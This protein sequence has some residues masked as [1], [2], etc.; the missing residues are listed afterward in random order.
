MAL[1][2]A[3]VKNMPT[4]VRIAALVI[5][6]AVLAAAVALS[7]APINYLVVA[8]VLTAGISL[9]LYGVTLRVLERRKI[10]PFELRLGENA[11]AAPNQ[12]RDPAARARLD[13]LRKKFE[14]GVRVFREH[15]KDLYSI[16]WYLVAGEPGSGKTEAVRHSGVGFPPGLQDELQGAGGTLNMNWWFTN[17]AVILDTAGRLLFEDVEPGTTSEWKE[18]LRLLRQIRPNCPVNGLLLVIPADSLVRDTGE[19]IEE[20]AGRIAAQ[21]DAIQ[22]SLGVRFPVFVVITKADLINGFREFFDEMTDPVVQHQILGWSNPGSLDDAFDPGEVERHLLSV[23]ERL[24]RRRLRLVGDPPKVGKTASRLARADALYAFPDSMIRLAPRLRR[25][26]EMVFV[27][28]EWSTR[29]LFLRGIYFT[30][31]MR[32]G[33][34]LDQDLAEVLGVDVGSLPEGRAWERDRSYFLRDLFLGKIFKER[35]LVTRAASASRSKRR[36]Q[37]A[38]LGAAAAAIVVVGVLTWIGN[39]QLREAILE[40]KKF[41]T[42]VEQLARNMQSDPTIFDLVY[43]DGPTDQMRYQGSTRAEVFDGS[44]NGVLASPAWGDATITD[45][46]KLASERAAKAPEPPPIFRPVASIFGNPFA[47]TMEAQRALFARTVLEPL[48]DQ[49]RSKLANLDESSWT[50]EATGALGELMRLE[51]DARGVAAPSRDM[52]NIERLGTFVLHGEPEAIKSLREHDAD[53]LQGVLARSYQRGQDWPPAQVRGEP[54]ALARTVKQGVETFVAHWSERGGADSRTLAEIEALGNAGDEYVKAEQAL[55]DLGP[56]ALTDDAWDAAFAAL[57]GAKSKLDEAW[58]AG[59]VHLTT[60][61][62]PLAERVRAESLDAAQGAF[63]RLLGQLPASDDPTAGDALAVE[64]RR[65]LESAWSGLEGT[66]ERRRLAAMDRVNRLEDSLRVDDRGEASYAARARALQV[67]D[68]VRRAG[69]GEGGP[70]M[71]PERLRKVA[72]S[73]RTGREQI[74]SVLGTNA[75]AGAGRRVAEFAGGALSELVRSR[76]GQILAATIDTLG[77]GVETVEGFVASRGEAHG[78]LERPSIPLT[79]MGGGAFEARYDPRAAREL[80]DALAAVRGA[81]ER[82]DGGIARS[83]ERLADLERATTE[84]ARRYLDY[85]CVQVP[86]DARPHIPGSWEACFTA[87]GQL[88]AR[89]VNSALGRLTQQIIDA[90]GA[91]PGDLSAQ[92]ASAARLKP[93]LE[94]DMPRLLTPR[95][96]SVE[97]DA[98]IENWRLLSPRVTSAREDVMRMTPRR[99]LNQLVYQ[100]DPADTKSPGMA[101]WSDLQFG[102]LVALANSAED[103]ARQARDRLATEAKGFPVCLDCEKA[104]TGDQIK[105]AARLVA[106]LDLPASARDGSRSTIGDGE[107]GGLP[108]LVQEQLKRVR[109][110]FVWASAAQRRWFERVRGAVAPLADENDKLEEELAL[111]RRQSQ[112]DQSVTSKYPTLEIWLGDRRLLI[113]GDRSAP[114]DKLNP[115]TGVRL[116]LPVEDAIEVRLFERGASE[117]SAVGR[118]EAP[119]S[120]LVAVRK[121]TGPMDPDDVSPE[122]LPVTGVWRLPLEL[123]TPDGRPI[124]A[125]SGEPVRYV[126]GVRF[127]GAPLAETAEWATQDSWP[128]ATPGSN[129]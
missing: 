16:P 4:P 3:S 13:D 83:R 105:D 70:E 122:G 118:L 79:S 74:A 41:W 57:Q 106:M 37:M 103:Q 52:L 81:V 24:L 12:L 88:S 11:G 55:L 107:M 86:K 9:A 85:W 69:V 68:T 39:G 64:L 128:S 1:V 23:R 123:K 75:N 115:S 113:S 22:R 20:K 77:G 47:Q 15:G 97:N 93:L 30:S 117:A 111:L 28:G 59:R 45:L 121:S 72:D 114:T 98:M 31:S 53:A 36:R 42:D 101:Y 8:L 108:T 84:Y 34:A 2:P 17:H 46:Q 63:Q 50:D 109:G 80:Y 99:F 110:D 65:T 25:Y 27:Q 119:W 76:S 96:L 19:Q 21:L 35:G 102:T 10:G 67:L 7:P 48:V 127:T 43:Y 38:V 66:I 49:T 26:L 51:L 120:G 33:S 100:Y 5:A 89:D 54:G 104:L 71:A 82:D 29:P 18:F 58:A 62:T 124:R 126:I 60:E 73:L 56:Q 6:A 87:L 91:V 95:Q 78:A 44:R 40:P 125:A 61:E 32:E 94:E 112:D 92:D 129:P 14:E 90:I 116:T